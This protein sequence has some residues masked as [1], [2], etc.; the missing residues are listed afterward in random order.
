MRTKPNTKEQVERISYE[1]TE[2]KAGRPY[3]YDDPVVLAG[4]INEYFIVCKD[5]AQPITMSGLAVHLGLARKSLLNYERH[6]PN[7]P[8]LFRAIKDARARIEASYEGKLV[9]GIP[10]TGLIFGL[11]NN[12]GWKDQMSLDVTSNGHSLF[13]NESLKLASKEILLQLDEPSSEQ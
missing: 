13:D 1:S 9:S 2:I 7:C 10:A 4:K 12:F 5:E 8:E 3:I 11:K 6:F